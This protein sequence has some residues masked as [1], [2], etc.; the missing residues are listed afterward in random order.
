MK[1]CIFDKLTP[2][3]NDVKWIYE[4]SYDMNDISI[5]GFTVAGVFSFETP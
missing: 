2:S 3:V 1:A 5:F 4:W